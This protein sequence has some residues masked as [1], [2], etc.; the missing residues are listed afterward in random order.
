MKDDSYP[1]D[2]TQSSSYTFTSI[3]KKRIDKQVVFTPTSVPNIVNMGF[4]DVLPDGSIDDKAN[5][6]NGDIVRVLATTVQILIDFT[7]KFPDIEIFFAGSTL[8]RTKLYTRVLRTYYYTFNKAFIIRGLIK[9]GEGY[10][11][12][13]FEPK[14]D[15][16][17]VG[18]L[19]KRIH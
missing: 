13:P 12:L 10:T 18:F 8:E 19:V 5:S 1:Y 15:L 2:R 7:S 3:G 11:E 6:N 14:A 16:K 17:F 9:D 4:G